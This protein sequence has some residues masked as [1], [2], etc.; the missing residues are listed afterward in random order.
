MENYVNDIINTSNK[1]S[2]I[3]FDIKDEWLGAILLAGLTDQ[4]KPL[5]MSIEGSGVKVTADL[6]KQKLLDTHEEESASGKV[7]LA[8][9]KSYFK[10]KPKSFECYTCGGKNHKSADCRHNKNSKVGDIQAPANSSTNRNQVGHGNL[11][12][13]TALM[14][15]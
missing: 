4:Y 7:F 11:A 6:I 13:H 14:N 8:K 5:I 10:S 15:S 12:K 9:N 3:G 2:G 1:L